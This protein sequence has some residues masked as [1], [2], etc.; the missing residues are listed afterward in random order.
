MLR[1]CKPAGSLA[2]A[3][4]VVVSARDVFATRSAVYFETL[5]RFREAG[6]QLAGAT[7]TMVVEPGQGLG[8]LFAPRPAPDAGD[9]GEAAP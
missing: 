9:G 4:G 7:T 6:V 5:R 8:S 3:E 2:R 1:P